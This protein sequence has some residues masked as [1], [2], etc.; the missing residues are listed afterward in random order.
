MVHGIMLLKNLIYRLID[1]GTPSQGTIPG[2]GIL[3]SVGWIWPASHPA[4]SPA[5]SGAMGD[6]PWEEVVAEAPGLC[7]T[8]CVA[9]PLTGNLGGKLHLGLL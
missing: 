7:K 5:Y 2:V 8:G 3:W 6:T 9:L 4:Q 1:K